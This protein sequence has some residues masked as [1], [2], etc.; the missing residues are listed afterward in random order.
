MKKLMTLAMAATL[1]FAAQAAPVAVGPALATPGNGLTATWVNSGSVH[2]LAAAEAAWADPSFAR[3]TQTVSN[4]YQT[5]NYGL[6]H[7][8]P[9]QPQPATMDDNF[10]VR[11]TG[12][13]NIATAGTYT[14][15]A[16][17]DDGF[18][19]KLGGE[20][21]M[22]YTID[23]GP[24]DS[25]AQVALSAGLYAIDFLVWEQGGMFVSE[26]DWLFPRTSNYALV[27]TSAL[28]TSAPQNVPEPASLALIGIALAALGRKRAAKT[29]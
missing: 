16:Y 27:P 9:A 19:F 21:L 17:T 1:S 29:R 22:S 12:Y 14:F 26:L 28:F 8:G 23:R 24:S 18:S 10:V 13:L 6:G 7:F 5:D 2:S 3:T 25:F 11:Y 15:R 4:I 20:T